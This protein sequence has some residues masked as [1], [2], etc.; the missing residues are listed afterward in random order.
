MA[1]RQAHHGGPRGAIDVTKMFLHCVTHRKTPLSSM[2][3][4]HLHDMLVVMPC[5]GCASLLQDVKILST[6]AQPAV[7]A[8]WLHAP[9]APTVLIY[10]HYGAHTTCVLRDIPY[11]HTHQRL[12]E[13]DDN[14]L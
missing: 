11:R 12:W 1:F 8:Q 4:H 5:K 3:L 13:E 14:G 10:G 9:D 7:Y 6:A 2:P